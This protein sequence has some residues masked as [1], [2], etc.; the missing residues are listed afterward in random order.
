MRYFLSKDKMPKL[1][2]KANNID[3]MDRWILHNAGYCMRYAV[4]VNP[5][6]QIIV[7]G[8]WKTLSFFR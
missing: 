1:I 6:V 7:K 8:E 3:L 4:R 2:L 5:K